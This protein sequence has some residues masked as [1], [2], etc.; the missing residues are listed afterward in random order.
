MPYTWNYYNKPK[1]EKSRR[2]KRA[3]H[4]PGHRMEYERNKKRI[5]ATQEICALCGKP[6][7]KTIKYPDPM[8]ATIDHIIPVSK[9]GHP[10]DIENLQLAHFKCN[11]AKSDRLLNEIHTDG[12]VKTDAYGAGDPRNL[13]LTVDWSRY[14]ASD[15]KGTG[16]NMHA[17]VAEA[18][19]IRDKGCIL[20]ARG[21]FPKD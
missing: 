15:R 14:E 19:S 1:K 18:D 10:S 4:Q 17:L 9:G 5:L 8:S 21:V 13:P 2:N 12:Q 20:T 6:V 11:R 3:D 7:D 16:G